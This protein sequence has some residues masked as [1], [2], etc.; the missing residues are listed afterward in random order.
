MYQQNDPLGLFGRCM[1]AIWERRIG[2]MKGCN[3]YSIAQGN[4][5]SNSNVTSVTVGNALTQPQPIYIVP[6]VY[7]LHEACQP[8]MNPVHGIALNMCT[9]VATMID[10]I[11]GETLDTTW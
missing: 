4:V 8:D 10:N 11:M 2:H 6:Q 3:E 1:G 7:Y 5:Y 9:V